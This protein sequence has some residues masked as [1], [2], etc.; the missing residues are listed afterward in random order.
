MQIS[1]IRLSDKTSRSAHSKGAPKAAEMGSHE[2][3]KLGDKSATDEQRATRKRRLIS[4]P[5]SFA[6]CGGNECPPSPS[7]DRRRSERTCGVRAPAQPASRRRR[8][9]LPCDL[10]ELD[11]EDLRRRPLVARKAVL[12]RLLRGAPAGVALNAHYEAA[13]AI[14]YQHACVLGCESIVSKR[15]GRRRSGRADI[16]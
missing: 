2:I 15:L 5:K 6:A 7:R 14:V 16:G 8:T 12:A 1:R 13:G 4:G 9:A 11:G 10:L 3:N